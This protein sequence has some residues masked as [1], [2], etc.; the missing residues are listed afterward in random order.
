MAKEYSKAEIAEMVKTDTLL[1]FY[2]SRSWKKLRQK[3]LELDKHECQR[4]KA[5]G[6]YRRATHVHHV[7]HVRKHPELAMSMI[8]KADDGAIRRNLISLCK[9]C[10]EEAH[11]E[12]LRWNKKELLNEERW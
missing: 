10:H 11:P 2:T 12:R 4:C 5:R 3:V 1:T 9:D 7:N 8:Y 6:W